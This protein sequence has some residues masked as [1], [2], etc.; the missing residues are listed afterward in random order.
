[1]TG[2][3]LEIKKTDRRRI[4]APELLEHWGYLHIS[5]DVKVKR[6]LKVK[7]DIEDAI[8]SPF[9]AFIHMPTVLRIEIIQNLTRLKPYIPGRNNQP[10]PSVPETEVHEK[11]IP[12]YKPQGRLLFKRS[13]LKEWIEASRVQTQEEYIQEQLKEK[14]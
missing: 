7:D 2:R 8:E 10:K 1:M 12:H 11:I 6:C 3:K 13:E 9:V 14:E 4:V 5:G